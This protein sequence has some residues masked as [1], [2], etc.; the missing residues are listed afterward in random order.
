MKKVI[1][2]IIK[3][4]LTLLT[5]V[6]T[7]FNIVAGVALINGN[8]MAM[9]LELIA[10]TVIGYDVATL[11]VWFRKEIIAGILSIAGSITLLTMRNEFY[12]LKLI[13]NN[14][15]ELFNTRH[16]PSLYITA[17]ILIFMIV[18]IILVIISMRRQ[19]AIKNREKAPSIFE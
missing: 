18:K 4:L 14:S 13:G 15:K 3:I 12:A 10:L 11:L 8:N 6:F 2:I 5:I 1:L 9:G 16:L 17:A 7:F 19:K